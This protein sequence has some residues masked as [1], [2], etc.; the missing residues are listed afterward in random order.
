MLTNEVTTNK[1]T[2]ISPSRFTGEVIDIILSES[3][4]DYKSPQDIGLI[5][6]RFVDNPVFTNS[7]PT[8]IALPLNPYFKQYPVLHELVTIFPA[9]NALSQSQQTTSYYYLCS[10]N[11]WGLTNLNAV[12]NSTIYAASDS[13]KT[14]S[15]NYSQFTGNS[16]INNNTDFK[17]GDTFEE[18]QKIKTLLPFE[19]DVILNGRFGNYI[20]FGSTTLKTNSP[21]SKQSPNGNP[22]I[23]IT[24]TAP[25][26]TKNIPKLEDI[27]KESSSV[28]LCD[29]QK[30]PIDII[31]KNL[32]SYGIG[33]S[34]NTLSVGKPKDFNQFA[35]KQIIISS[36]R[37]LFQSKEDSIFLNSKTSIGLSTA[38]TINI[39]ADKGII[40][41]SPKIYLGARGKD[42]ILRGTKFNNDIMQPLLQELSQMQ[43]IINGTT[44]TVSPTSISK[45][46]QLIGKLQNTLSQKTYT[47]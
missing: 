22:I 41:N 46:I 7:A 3:H 27:N 36:D 43:I 18:N 40:F 35:G 39:D 9:G 42:A 47:E 33:Q 37:L 20:R 13:G 19:G 8:E 34:G 16:P 23:I 21:W 11:S 15:T 2:N 17:F 5:K 31:S 6:F 14:K 29:G 10:I 28:L 30:I 38:G 1:Q 44:G 45:F 24:N 32:K 4:P 26:E 12:P 25:T